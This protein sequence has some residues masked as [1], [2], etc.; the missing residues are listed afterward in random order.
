MKGKIFTDKTVDD[1][2]REIFP[3]LYAEEEQRI[4]RNKAFSDVLDKVDSAKVPGTK[5]SIDLK[6]GKGTCKVTKRDADGNESTVREYDIDITN[7]KPSI[8]EKGITA[9]DKL[10]EKQSREI[11]IK[12]KEEKLKELDN[13]LA[14]HDAVEGFKDF[15]E[16][17]EQIRHGLEINKHVVPPAVD[18][19][20]RTNIIK[21]N[22]EVLNDGNFMTAL[23]ELEKQLQ[24]YENNIQE[25]SCCK[26]CCDKVHGCKEGKKKD[27][28]QV[29]HPEHYNQ[30]SVEAIDMIEKVYGLYLAWKWCEITAFKYRL[31][32]GTKPGN[33]LAQDLEKEK[34]YL[35]KAKELKERYMENKNNTW[36]VENLS[37]RDDVTISW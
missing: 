3:S 32:M 37:G 1:I 14:A 24:E 29:N 22:P 8:V 23:D 21:N 18:D 17:D 25:K 10:K 26:A 5:A 15:S 2:F 11:P 16:Q 12:T 34:W 4:D 33:E 27:Y 13:T 9:G 31:R 30:Y 28:E 35:N 6:N 7:D 19:S 20:F 36:D